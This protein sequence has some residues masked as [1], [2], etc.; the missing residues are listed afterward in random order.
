MANQLLT[1]GMVTMEGLPVLENQLKFTKHVRRDYDRDFGEE[2]AQIGD[3][4]A[5]RKP[6]RFVGRSGQGF[7]AE[8]AT[9]TSVQLTLTTQFGVDTFFTSKDFALNIENFTER[10]LDPAMARIA[11]KIDSDGLLQYANVANFVGVPGTVPNALLTYL[12][13]MQ[14]L[15]DNAAALEPRAIVISQA[16][17]PQI[18]DAL[19]GL[20]EPGSSISEQYESGYMRQAIGAVWE[21]DQNVANNTIGTLN[22]ATTV[23]INAGGQSGASLV[24][25]NAGSVTNLFNKGNCF[26]IGS[27]STGVYAV[28]P[29]EKTQINSLQCFTV[30]AN[31]TSSGGAATVPIYPAIVLSGPFQNVNAAPQSG[32]TINL[33]GAAATVSPQGLCFHKGSFALGTA[34]LPIIRSAEMC[35]RKASDQLGLSVRYLK[36]YD[37]NQDRLP[38]RFDVLY[39]WVTLY[40]ETACRIMS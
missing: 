10:F 34:D 15:N 31:V 20:L 12:Q 6:P 2:G 27:G 24:C 9:E 19:K 21:M 28:N 5:I 37:Y 18:V 7:N 32:A 33:N 1:I 36:A 25:N 38:G 3:T 17:E 26:T 8:D 11:N 22:G 30:T 39:G 23:T 40:P 35:E 4:L 14:K 13:S 29:Q 16:M